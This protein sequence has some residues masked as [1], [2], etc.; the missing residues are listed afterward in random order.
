MNPEDRR[1]FVRRHRTA[2][3]GYP[4]KQDGPAMSIVCYAMEGEEILVSTMAVRAKARAVARSPK[5]RSGARGAR[6]RRRRPEVADAR[7]PRDRY[8]AP[9]GPAG[10]R[11]MW[12]IR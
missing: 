4:R 7:E 5:G 12:P 11:C 1:Q 3:L 2:I 10:C 9:A 6:D 8:R